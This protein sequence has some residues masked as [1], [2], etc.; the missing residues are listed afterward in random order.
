MPDLFELL[1][2]EAVRQRPALAPEF[3]ALVRAHRRRTQRN[4]I[5]GSATTLT[6]GALVGGLVLNGGSGPS[7]SRLNTPPTLSGLTPSVCTADGLTFAFDWLGA[8]GGSLVGKL[9]V[10]NTNNA[11]CNVLIRPHVTPLDRAGRPLSVTYGSTVEA[12]SG[13]LKL[14]PGASA[15]SEVRWFGWCGESPGASVRIEWATASGST[16]A[17]VSARGSQQPDCPS[18]PTASQGITSSWFSLSS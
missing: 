1:Q 6:V 14:E 8:T 11:A 16:S 4:R 17:N 10:T 12:R 5:A 2:D 3:G 15:E 13:Q 18:D 9:V 7:P